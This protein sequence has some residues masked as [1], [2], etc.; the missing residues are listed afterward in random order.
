[1]FALFFLL[2]SQSISHRSTDIVITGQRLVEAQAECVRAGCTPLRDARASIAVAEVQFRDGAYLDAKKLLSAAISRN[3]DKAAEA[4]RAVAALY[5]AYATVALHEGDQLAYRRAVANQVETLKGN[6]PPGDISVVAA[7]TALGDMW[8]TLGQYRKADAAY[9]SV[10][11]DAVVGGQDRSAMLAGMKRTWL[12]AARGDRPGALKMLDALETRPIAREPG[13]WT[14]LRV[15]RLRV[16]ARNA[17]D[18]AISSLIAEL[19]QDANPVLIWAPPYK[20]NAAAA[21]NANARKFGDPDVIPAGSADLDGIQWVDIG[22]WIRPDGRTAEA[23]I[24]RGSRSRGWVAPALT[25]IGGRRYAA[26]TVS[27]EAVQG[28]AGGTYRI[29]RFTKRTQYVTPKG[30]LIARRVAIGGFEIV[31]ITGT[32]GDPPS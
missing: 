25:Q 29:E 11:K 2:Q 15:L 24:L 31:D 6:L 10:E 30:S 14:A 5:E 4:P 32:P 3:R 13:F 22:F 16:A 20:A 8:L 28:Q 12:A 21:A 26:S 1:M 27:A 18:K 23:E 17:D 19:G 7:A 9:S